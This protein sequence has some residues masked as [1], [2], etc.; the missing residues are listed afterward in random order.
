MSIQIDPRTFT[1]YLAQARF[2]THGDRYERIY[3]P[4]LV[5]A[6][7]SCELLWRML[8]LPL[9]MRL[10]TYPN[11]LGPEISFRPQVSD[12]LQ[13]IASANYSMAIHF[14]LAHAALEARTD[15]SLELTYVHL[16]SACDLAETVMEKWYVLLNSCL[17]NQLPP[18]AA[19]TRDQFLAIAA[20]WY[21]EA[22]PA[23]CEHYLDRGK[24][25]PLKILS[26]ED[27]VNEY[28]ADHPARKPFATAAQHIRTIRNVI[29]HDVNLARVY[30]GNGTVLIPKAEVISS[31]RQWRAVAAVKN[32]Q[33]KI[34][35][36]F[37]EQY[38]Q[39]AG[40]MTALL[41][42]LERIWQKI[43]GE[44]DREFYRPDPSPLRGKY[45]IGFRQDPPILIVHPEEIPHPQSENVPPSGTYSG[46][47]V[48][49]STG[50]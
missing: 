22:F 17:G 11:A 42:V 2:Q 1:A 8:A 15:F 31:Y 25:P 30:Q 27:L 32:D 10:T 46:G 48:D 33:D 36:D 29:I 16:A 44:F 23:F 20:S 39:A 35:R 34:R 18:F 47:S 24:S 37:I 45:D 28:L 12:D 50:H 19:T 26:R 9:T 6:F 41:S 7:P 5:V 21:D 49:F 4:Y 13:D 3:G 43:L 14:S 40:H 38:S